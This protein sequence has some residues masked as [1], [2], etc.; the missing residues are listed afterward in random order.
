MNKNIIEK[1]WKM[2]KKNMQR[3]EKIVTTFKIQKI[4]KTALLLCGKSDMM[5]GKV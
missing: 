5:I 1:I 4:M 2:C 3:E